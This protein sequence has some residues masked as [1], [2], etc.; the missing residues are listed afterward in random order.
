[1]QE[2]ENLKL[3]IFFL[4]KEFESGKLRRIKISIFLN[5]LIVLIALVL[6]FKYHSCVDLSIRDNE[7]NFCQERLVA[8]ERNW[9]INSE[10]QRVEIFYKE[11]WLAA[12][13]VTCRE[14]WAFNVPLLI[15]KKRGKSLN[16]FSPRGDRKTRKRKNDFGLLK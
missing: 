9:A 6:L 15:E 3:W 7:K 12:A 2:D 11:E 14:S 1:M 16:N 5:S 4:L 10:K 8:R 13:W